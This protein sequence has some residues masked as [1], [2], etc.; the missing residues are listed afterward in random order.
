MPPKTRRASGC[1]GGGGDDAEDASPSRIDRATAGV[2]QRQKSSYAPRHSAPPTTSP[3]S[4]GAADIEAMM[5][6]TSPRGERAALAP[7]RSEGE[8]EPVWVHYYQKHGGK[9][10]FGCGGRVMIGPS[11]DNAYMLFAWVAILAPS[12]AYWGWAKPILVEEWGWRLPLSAAS[13][14]VATMV[15]MLATMFTD[16]GFLM[17]NAQK[18]PAVKP[19]QDQWG[20]PIGPPA[21]EWIQTQIGTYPFTWCITCD[22]WRPPYAHHCVDCGHCVLGFDHHCPFVNN[23]IGVRNH[24][25]FFAFISSVCG[26]G[27]VVLAGTLAAMYIQAGRAADEHVALSDDTQMLIL[28]SVAVPVTL[29]TLV[30]I[31]FVCFHIYICCKASLADKE[32]E[33]KKEVP[34]ARSASAER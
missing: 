4:S 7:A 20:R 21:R 33:A 10:R 8:E 1:G 32:R 15:S 29:L 11:I 23:C 19:R 30:L 25:Y 12:A 5:D 14:F 16:P 31:F 2:L 9:M 13:L 22:I 34:P 17:K 3:R 26:L 6:P 27:V 24:V 18:G 28:G